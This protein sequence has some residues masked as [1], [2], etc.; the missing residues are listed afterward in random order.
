MLPFTYYPHNIA[1]Q[2]LIALLIMVQG[3]APIAWR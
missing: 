3:A 1:A 2:N